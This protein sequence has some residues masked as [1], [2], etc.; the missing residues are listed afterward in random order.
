M[1]VNTP[2][3]PKHKHGGMDWFDSP[4]WRQGTASGLCHVIPGVFMHALW[5]FVCVCMC[6]CVSKVL[7]GLSVWLLKKS[8]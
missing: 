8:S 7:T 5:V 1:P 2:T 6:V 4:T 3:D